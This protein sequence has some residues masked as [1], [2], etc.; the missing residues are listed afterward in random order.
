MDDKSAMLASS[1]HRCSENTFMA[2]YDL[3]H[4][5]R[6]YVVQSL[7]SH[8]AGAKLHLE[9]QGF[10]TFLP[11][12]VKTVRHARKLR[13][14]RAP[15]FPGYQFIILDLA[16]DRWRSVNGTVRVTGMIMGQERPI[17]VPHGVVERLIDYL[18]DKGV[19]RFDRDLVDGQSVRV[20][21]GPFAEAIGTLMQCDNKGRVRVLLDIMGGKVPVALD[22]SSLTAA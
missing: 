22:R 21:T 20:T 4:A 9:A 5:E 11:Q 15:V 7:A 8:E 6:W 12:I 14:V 13:T 18:D 10:R 16:R 2:P 19:C 17:P 3:A 1:G